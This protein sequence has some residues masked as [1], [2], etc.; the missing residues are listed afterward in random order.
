MKN[1]IVSNELVDHPDGS[2]AALP[3]DSEDPATG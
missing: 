2:V 3:D 1:Y